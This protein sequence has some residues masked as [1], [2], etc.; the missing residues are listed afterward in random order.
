MPD[1]TIYTTAACPYCLRAKALLREKNLAFKEIAVDG[2][3]EA[4]REMMLRA[5]GRRTVPQI[6]FDGVHIGDCDELHELDRNG[7]L[8]ELLGGFV[9]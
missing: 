4:R 6:F 9:P 2:N 5:R 1:V 8:D 7:K 3:P